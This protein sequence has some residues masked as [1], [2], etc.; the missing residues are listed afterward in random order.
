MTKIRTVTELHNLPVL[1]EVST[2]SGYV[3]TKQTGGRWSSTHSAQIPGRWLLDPE[4]S[5]QLI[6]LLR[7]V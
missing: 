3:Y 7:D 5:V 6:T 1:T 4:H 2:G